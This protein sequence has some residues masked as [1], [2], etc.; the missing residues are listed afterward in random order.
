[1]N[2]LETEEIRRLRIYKSK[3]GLSF[4]KLGKLLDCHSL[5]IYHWFH[6]HQ[7]PSDM[8]K[9]LINAFLDKIFFLEEEK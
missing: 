4:D 2:K 9:K 1:M 7:R 6:G 5:T 3:S 8:A